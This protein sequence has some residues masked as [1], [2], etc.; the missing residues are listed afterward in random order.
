MCC[1]RVRQRLGLRSTNGR[2]R[3][4]LKDTLEI[5]VQH[6]KRHKPRMTGLINKTKL[7]IRL[8]DSWSK[9]Q[10]LSKLRDIVEAIHDLSHIPAWNHYVAS[11]PSLAFQPAQLDKLV[12]E[13]SKLAKYRKV[14]TYLYRTARKYPIARSVRVVAVE[15]PPA[16]FVRTPTGDYSAKLEKVF[17]RVGIKKQNLAN[18]LGVLDLQP[19][20]AKSSFEKSTKAIREK[21]GIHAEVQLLVYCDMFLRGRKPRVICSSKKACFLCNVLINTHGKI[22]TPY[23]HGRMYPKWRLPK[24]AGDQ[25]AKQLSAA[26]EECSR[27]SLRQM[28]S[29][30]KRIKHPYP[31]ES[32][33]H[34][35]LV[36]STTLVTFNSD[37]EGHQKASTGTQQ[38]SA[39]ITAHG[40]SRGRRAKAHV[41]GVTQPGDLEYLLLDQATGACE[42]AMD[43]SKASS[44]L[45]ATTAMSTGR[46][47]WK[48]KDFR[49]SGGLARSPDGR[50]HDVFHSGRPVT[51][52]LTAGSDNP[53][54]FIG[55]CFDLIIEREKSY[56]SPDAGSPARHV[57]CDIAWV[58]AEEAKCDI[59]EDGGVV[60]DVQAL[61]Q[62]VSFPLGKRDTSTFFLSNGDS[63][64]V[65][66]VTLKAWGNSEVWVSEDF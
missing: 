65:L 42:E 25:V 15:L 19:S 21:S 54:L 14:A 62:E 44:D 6:M 22:Y 5:V 45:T 46:P 58:T 39:V 13:V 17:G 59:R 52:R 63:S 18:I 34:T 23:S 10:V 33:N 51:T 61:D 47:D 35:L 32:A 55:D 9:H 2:P 3:K 53:Q 48:H 49:E 24:V 12:R 8:I 50:G 29:E 56:S 28:K 7:I 41:D 64:G 60:V 4:P 37:Q 31:D 66:R 27:R 36:S 16:M 1:E 38:C 26:L 43:L 57:S 40:A 11:S 30:N 20:T